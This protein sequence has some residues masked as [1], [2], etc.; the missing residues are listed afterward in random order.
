MEILI[1]FSNVNILVLPM[2]GKILGPQDKTGIRKE[3]YKH[4]DRKG[5]C[6]CLLYTSDAADE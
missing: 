2:E 4:R 1:Q 5:Y 3:I 6:S